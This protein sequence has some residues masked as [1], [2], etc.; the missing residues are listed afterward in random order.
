MVNRAV[1]PMCREICG[2]RREAGLGLQAGST[3]EAEMKEPGEGAAVW[4]QK[5]G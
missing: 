4:G 3:W 5:E 2:C 1:T